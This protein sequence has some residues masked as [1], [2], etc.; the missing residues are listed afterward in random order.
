MSENVRRHNQQNGM[1]IGQ[2]EEEVE[3][4]RVRGG[5]GRGRTFTG[6][7]HTSG[8]CV[9]THTPLPQPATEKDVALQLA[10]VA[11]CGMREGQRHGYIRSRAR[12]GPSCS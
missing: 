12:R 2:K 6:K 11:A 9:Q 7:A 3:D 1:T 10:G 4:E 5:K 8:V